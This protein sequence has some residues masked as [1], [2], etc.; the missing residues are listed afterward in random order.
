MS[1]ENKLGVFGAIRDALLNRNASYFPRFRNASGTVSRI[2]EPDICA[3]ISRSL[4]SLAAPKNGDLRPYLERGRETLDEVKGL[5]EYQDEKATRILT[6]VAFLS[7]LSGALFSHL[8]D[9]YPLYATIERFGYCLETLLVFVAYLS[10]MLFALSAACGALV[11]FHATRTRFKYPASEPEIGGT[12][13]THPGSYLFYSDIIELRPE[14]WAKA[15]L[16]PPDAS[17]P[18]TPDPRLSLRYLKNYI[19]ESYLV[20]AKVADKLRY[21]QTAQDIL[22]FAVRMLVIWLLLFAITL[23]MVPNVA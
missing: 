23:A 4:E 5:T 7:A 18:N 13:R 2:S 16:S 1:R 11:V 21:L 6:I 19:V 12:R 20:A 9:K 17:T 14:T 3:E 15:F 10:F 22:A 8:A